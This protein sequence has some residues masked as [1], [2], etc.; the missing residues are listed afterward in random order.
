M[1]IALLTAFLLLHFG[2]HSSSVAV[3]FEQTMGLVKA[4]VADEARQKQALTI[5]EQMK[6]EATTYSER[7]QKSLEELVRLTSLRTTPMEEIQH[8]AQPLITD[9]R[10]SA[11]KLLDLR[12]KLKTVLTASEWPK[13]F[14]AAPISAK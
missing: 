4:N 7:R 12:F 1:L 10:A 5:V 11:E 3:P 14:P 13:V 8:A 2:S 6:S 9:D